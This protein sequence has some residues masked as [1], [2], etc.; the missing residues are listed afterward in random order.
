VDKLGQVWILPHPSFSG[1]IGYNPQTDMTRYF[2]TSNGNLPSANVTD[3]EIDI[4]GQVWIA[5]ENGLVFLPFT[6]GVLED[7]SVDA[8]EPIFGNRVLFEGEKISA[9]EV[10]AANRK[11]IA[12]NNGLWLFEDDG[13]ELIYNF[14]TENSPLPS[15]NILDIKTNPVSGEVFIATAKGLVSFRSDAVEGKIFH[16]SVKIFP[17][18][19]APGYSGLVGITGLAQD[20]NLKITDVS[21][22]LVREINAA[23]GGASWDVA[24]YNGIRV[25]TG[26]YLIFSSN[27]DG[28]E[29]F[30]GKMA[31]VN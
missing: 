17:N 13:D 24:D 11:W 16:Q 28:T 30:V 1:I 15:N 21:G 5:T 4:S 10:D 12:T 18:P 20:A 29:T 25:Q 26:I 7:N 27:N 6:F 8:L 9:I 31:V 23:G 3:L 22:K 19:V 14:N 2:T